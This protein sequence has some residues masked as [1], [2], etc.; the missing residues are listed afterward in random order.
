MDW[1]W[2]LGGLTEAL[3][4]PMETDGVT[5]YFFA[6]AYRANRQWRVHR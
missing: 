6:Q 3:D 2:H 4:E 1:E 5:V